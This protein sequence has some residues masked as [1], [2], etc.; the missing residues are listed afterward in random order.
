MDFSA[1]FQTQE[2]EEVDWKNKTERRK[3]YENDVK[4]RKEDEKEKS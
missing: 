3:M 2:V 4:E 1:I